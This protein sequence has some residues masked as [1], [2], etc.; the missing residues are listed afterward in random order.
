MIR[1]VLP[2]CLLFFFGLVRAET[3]KDREGAVRSDAAKMEGS[4]RWI[5]NDIEA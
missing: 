3:V 2:C 4:D 1:F 5:Y